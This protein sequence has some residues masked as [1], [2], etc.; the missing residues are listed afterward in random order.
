MHDLKSK[1]INKTSINYII[2]FNLLSIMK[3]I[4]SLL[5][6]MLMLFCSTAF[7]Q[8][9]V[10]DTEAEGLI[11]DGSQFSSPYSQNDLGNRDGGDFAE[12]VL[13]DG[14][15]GTFWHS[16]WGGGDVTPGKHYF[17]VDLAEVPDYFGFYYV[18]RNTSNDHTTLWAV[19]GAETDDQAKDD[20]VLLALV[21]TP[22][23]GSGKSF[24][25]NPIPSKGFTKLRFYHEEGTGSGNG[26]R[27]YFHAAEFQLYPCVEISDHDA[28]L[29]DL[30]TVYA[31][32]SVYTGSFEV[33]TEPGQ[34]GEAEVE[35]F[36]DALNKAAEMDGPAG[37]EATA[38]ELRALAQA[39]V[40]TYNAVLA[41]RVPYA[42]TVEEGYYYL[43]SALEWTE[44]G[45]DTTDPETGE[46]MPGETL[47]PTKAAY[48]DG[49]NAKWGNINREDAN[50]LWK[51]V[52][53]G[54]K[55]YH[56]I[57]AQ[58][59]S[60][61]V[62][63]K[64]S[65]A[66]TLSTESDSLMVFDVAGV[67]GYYNIRLDA[68]PERG[69]QYMHCEGHGG[70]TGK[71]GN[72]VGWCNTYEGTFGASEWTLEAVDEATALAIIEACSPAKKI[73]AMVD[74]IAVI[75]A[76][77]PAQKIVCL[78]ETA[79]INEEIQ[80]ANA[81]TFLSPFTEASEGSV[82]NLF[83]ED[84]G[85]FWHA[86]WNTSLTGAKNT[87]PGTNY[88]VINDVN[89]EI[90]G[91]LAVK[92]TRRSGAGDDHV[93]QFVV[94]GTDEYDIEA[95]PMGEGY[96]GLSWTEIGTLNIPFEGNTGTV[97]SN[98]ISLTKKYNYYKFL[99]TDCKGN[100]YGCRGY[101]HMGEFR[102]YPAKISHAVENYQA[103]A[104]ANEI[105]AVDAAL[106]AWNAIDLDAVETA[107]E[108][109]AQFEALAQAYAAFVAVYV[110]PAPL[111]QA[112][113]ATAKEEAIKIGSNPGEWSSDAA[114]KAMAAIR[115]AAK[116]YDA[117]G[118]YTTAQS[119]DYIAQLAAADSVVYAS[120]NG[121][122]EGK[123]YTISFPTEEEYE[124]NGWSKDGDEAVMNED[125]T[126]RYESLFG[127]VA[128][129]GHEVNNGSDESPI[130]GYEHVDGADAA[131]EDVVRVTDKENIDNM[132]N[133]LFRLVAI[134]D[135]AFA[136][137]NKATGLY[138]KAA[139]TSGGVTVS[140]QPSLFSQ[141][142]IGYGVNLIYAKG[143]NGD[144]QA[145]L[146]MQRD[147]NYLVTWGAY[148]VGTRSALKLQEEGDVKDYT[149]PS[150]FNIAVAPGAYAGRCLPVA[151][152]PVEGEDVQMY[153][154]AFDAE[155]YE[156]SL[157]PITEAAAGR[158][159]VM[160]SG[161]TE[162]YSEEAEAEN[163]KFV[164]GDE[165]VAEP[166][167]NQSLAGTFFPT[168]LEKGNMY[169]S[170][171]GATLLTSNATLA[172]NRAYVKAE[173]TRTEEGTWPTI[174]VTVTDV[175]A[176]EATLETVAK[177]NSNIYTIDGK[178]VGKGNINSLKT[179]GIYVINGVKV[180]VK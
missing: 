106:E 141:K 147:H 22:G 54:D 40:D 87:N 178:L 145:V 71:G 25:S 146:H 140:V 161:S 135:S 174:I 68:A 92:V 131:I 26:S 4:T 28:A 77:Y 151:V 168:P 78:D 138:L 167:E 91:G 60:Q 61:F 64:Q 130:W 155:K 31:Q 82:E 75:K 128:A 20:C 165:L 84:G 32:Y 41:S 7:A 144:A 27:G 114:Y 74:S 42:T 107:D 29:Q 124:A 119:E 53:A 45:E 59:E 110:D 63:C 18:C 17:Q 80:I 48:T 12:N 62:A 44:Q 118:K 76:A 94:Y 3:K 170:A 166:L 176:I 169:F 11:T 129:V 19:Y 79:E 133:A 127:K 5:S 51:V 99:C 21:E 104:R 89:Q 158:P 125:E 15:N 14:D 47:Y 52:S 37:E 95:D 69:Y 33:G 72:I 1:R 9:M 108:I 38:E 57:N 148:E 126:T 177:T 85:T 49:K 6:L 120:A 36:E 112:V 159:F 66:A 13:I 172:A 8:T 136:L 113:A 10:V 115:D 180:T 73:K 103:L 175:D 122:K 150:T 56:L 137:Q 58:N 162:D 16:Y 134:G 163:I 50:F 88:F 90:E 35:A 109:Q 83:D 102:M 100:T 139:G 55:K 157:M 46:T 96:E 101:F 117:T 86:A 93:T 179:R 98:A 123:W 43:V 81:E 39:I 23:A 24:W 121:L 156:I 116:A 164:K 160:I 152:K 30:I 70:G 149:A 111:R 67:E 173:V 132:D 154:A 34:Y 2:N 142:A 105:A 143:I 65:T 171:T 97:T 153:T